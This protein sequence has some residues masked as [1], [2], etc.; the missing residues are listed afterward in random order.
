MFV[1]TKYGQEHESIALQ[2]FSEEE[3]ILITRYGVII[4]INYP[5]FAF[6][7]DGFIFRG[8]SSVELLEVKCPQEGIHYK[9]G[10]ILFANLCLNVNIVIEEQKKWT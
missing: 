4:N 3:N 5:H 7:P 8:D 9:L 10:L 1:F 2:K 6:S